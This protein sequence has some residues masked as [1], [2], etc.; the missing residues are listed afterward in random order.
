MIDG[1][2]ACLLPAASCFSDYALVL[3]H[4]ADAWT[5]FA[6]CVYLHNLHVLIRIYIYIHTDE[7]MANIRRLSAFYVCSVGHPTKAGH[8]LSRPVGHEFISYLFI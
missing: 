5:L 7:R 1:Y 2:A 4:T 6:D 3:L 8:N